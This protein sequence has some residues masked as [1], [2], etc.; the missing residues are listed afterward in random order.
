MPTPY[1]KIKPTDNQSLS[2][3]VTVISDSV[4]CN[5]LRQSS[6]SSGFSCHID[7]KLSDEVDDVPSVV[8]N[9]PSFEPTWVHVFSKSS[10]TSSLRTQCAAAAYMLVNIELD[11]T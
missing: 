9:P 5:P 3:P 8:F 4:H 7:D 10:S 11:L 1:N 6:V 2:P